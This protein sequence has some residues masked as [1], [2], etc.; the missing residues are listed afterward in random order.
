MRPSCL[1]PAVLVATALPALAN[2]TWTVQDPSLQVRPDF[3][4]MTVSSGKGFLHGGERIAQRSADLAPCRVMVVYAPGSTTPYG[5]LDGTKGKT[6]KDLAELCG[7]CLQVQA[8]DDPATVTEIGFSV[9]DQAAFLEQKGRF[10][11][12]VIQAPDTQAFYLASPPKAPT[13]APDAGTQGLTSL[14]G[15]EG[16]SLGE[17][18]EGGVEAPLTRGRPRP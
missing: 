13:E 15:L 10:A 11:Q 1:F 17:G 9:N 16:L 5:T 14:P 8:K 6:Y 7:Q 18:R 12:V 2:E 3:M 4:R